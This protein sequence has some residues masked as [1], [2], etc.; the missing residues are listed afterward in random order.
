MCRFNYKLWIPVFVSFF[1]CLYLYESFGYIDTST[2]GKWAKVVGD[3]QDGNTVTQTMI[4]TSNNIY[5]I[6]FPVPTYYQ[7]ELEGNVM[8]VVYNNGE[9]VGEKIVK[10]S[11]IYDWCSITVPLHKVRGKIGDELKIEIS[12]KNVKVPLAIYAYTENISGS[13]KLNIN[14]ELELNAEIAFTFKTKSE[15]ANNVWWMFAIIVII[16]FLNNKIGSIS[17]IC[18]DKKGLNIFKDELGR[19]GSYIWWNR[20][21]IIVYMLVLFLVYGAWF[22]G[23]N[24]HFDTEVFVNNPYTTYNWLDIGR[25]GLVL[26]EYIFGLRLFNPFVATSFGFIMLWFSGILFGYLIW[27]TLQELS[28]VT[29]LF[30][31]FCFISP[32]LV[33]QLYFDIQIFQIA[34]A[35]CLCAIGAGLSY[36][37]ILR[38]SVLVKSLAILCMIWAF[39]S[40]QTFVVI[41]IAI[42]IVCYILLYHRWTIKG[43]REVT[44]SEYGKLIAWQIGLFCIA[45][46]FNTVITKFFF[47]SSNYLNGNI[48]W[49]KMKIGQIVENLRN[50]F[51][52]ALLGNGIFYTVFFGI[53][54]LL[55]ITQLYYNVI[56]TKDKPI[57]WIYFLA[58]VGVQLTPFLLAVCV[59]QK[60]VIR[61]ELVYPFVVA[62]DILILMGTSEKKLTRMVYIILATLMLVEQAN[63]VTRMIYTDKIRTQED[64]RLFEEIDRKIKE[65]APEK[66]TVAFVGT[67]KAKLN[68]SCIR[69][70]LIGLSITDFDFT[71][72]PHY[73]WGSYRICTLLQ[74]QGFSYINV[75]QEQMYE[76]RVRALKMP[77]WPKAGSIIDAGEYII[78]KLSEDQWPEEVMPTG[79]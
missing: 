24:L 54:S 38:K 25:Y 13:S 19:F 28:Y 52:Q 5:S 61:S 53:F 23:N 63:L 4:R 39:A 32:I 48:A 57:R 26:T 11:E 59:G 74:T 37:G 42:V 64:I 8:V 43:T 69:G 3:F 2:G 65:I 9:C 15:Y 55:T 12:T 31:L 17:R 27:R 40:Y 58:G 1:I 10:G 46:V 45:M 16:C 30:G 73:F 47:S 68:N 67:Y 21:F 35:Y 44:S 20:W 33:E 6:S 29:I 14:N 71:G 75:T 72:I 76:A 51:V 70:D 22:Y 34:W 79:Y 49:G 78:V 77:S 56:K 60:T 7:D 36:Y 41:H 18:V 50:Y 62:S 66:K